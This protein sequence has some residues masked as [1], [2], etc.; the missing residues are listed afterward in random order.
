VLRDTARSEEQKC[1]AKLTP[2]DSKF[3]SESSIRFMRL[4]SEEVHIIK[5]VILALDPDA[6]IY[7]FGSRV[8]DNAKGGD[9]DLLILSKQLVQEDARSI[10]TALFEHI[11]E[12]KIDL[13]I[14]KNNVDPFVKIALEKGILL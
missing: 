2:A 6:K 13:V 14:A 7:L 3:L 11:E 10:R 1:A 12:Q 5:S 9:I 8:D 4:T